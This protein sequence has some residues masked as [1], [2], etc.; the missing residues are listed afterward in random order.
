MIGVED[1]KGVGLGVGELKGVGVIVGKEEV[2]EGSYLWVGEGIKLSC[3]SLNLQ[4]TTWVESQLR[5]NIFSVSQKS[6]PVQKLGKLHLCIWMGVNVG[7]SCL[8]EKR[9]ELLD[10]R[11]EKGVGEIEGVTVG[12]D[13]GRV[14]LSVVVAFWIDTISTVIPSGFIISTKEAVSLY[15]KIIP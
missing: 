8:V 7:A 5:G 13:V 12:A 15:G 1:I 9:V 3:G 6:G 10:M 14:M 4:Q 2:G 11:F